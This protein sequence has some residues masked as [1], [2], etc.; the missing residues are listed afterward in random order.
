MLYI[1]WRSICSLLTA[2]ISINDVVI[3]DSLGPKHR[4]ARRDLSVGIWARC[5]TSGARLDG[6]AKMSGML[7]DGEN[8][9]WTEWAD[10]DSAS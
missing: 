5:M 10:W 9:D 8:K 1:S 2:S 6:D 7:L 3:L 4:L